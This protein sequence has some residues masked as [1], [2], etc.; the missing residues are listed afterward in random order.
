MRVVLRDV[1]AQ[2]GG[3]VNRYQADPVALAESRPHCHDEL[4]CNLVIRGNGSYLLSTRRCDLS[5]GCLLWLFPRQEHMLIDHSADFQMW[6]AV[7]S[8]E[9]ARQ[10]AE[11]LQAPQLREDD[12]TGYFC[13]MLAGPAREDLD[14]LCQALCDRTLPSS[15]RREG[16]AWLLTQAWTAF[17]RAVTIEQLP[18]IDPVIERAVQLLQDPHQAWRLPEL[19]RELRRSPS[20]ISRRFHRELGMTLSDF[21]NRQ[22]LTRFFDSHQR[23]AHANL[24]E[25][26]LRAGF[27]SYPQFTRVFRTVMG[28]GPRGYLRA[29]SAS[30]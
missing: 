15:A 1:D 5:R 10:H 12:P 27:T 17:Q 26:A 18:S 21:R 25:L 20:W 30:G 14:R 2:M 16:L 13:R 4:E 23:H 6:V 7:F 22:R 24:L 9:M 8:P 29:S 3:M 11:S 19:S 28:Q